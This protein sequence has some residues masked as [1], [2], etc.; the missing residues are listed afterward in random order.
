MPYKLRCQ[1]DEKLKKLAENP[2][3][4][5][6]DIIKLQGHDLYRLRSGSYRIIYERQDKELLITVIRIADRKEV[7]RL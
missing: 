4:N 2:N 1:I 5:D 6:L 3:R 7:Y